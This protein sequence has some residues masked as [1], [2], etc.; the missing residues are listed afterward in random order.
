[1]T[2]KH[3]LI[4]FLPRFLWL[5][6]GLALFFGASWQNQ[7]AKLTE[8]PIF[9]IFGAILGIVGIFYLIWTFIFIGKGLFSKSLVTNGPYK[10]TRHP[11]YF[12]I[13]LILTGLGILFFN[14]IWF[15]ILA[16][17]IPF[18]YFVCRLEEKQMSELHGQK[19]LE[20]QKQVGMFFPKKLP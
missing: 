7:S 2:R 18:W 17:F 6:E 4:E 10:Y 9:L 5:I 16:G 12:A 1:M 3:L 15:A 19:Y 8:S 11:M 13:Y 20:Y 14:W